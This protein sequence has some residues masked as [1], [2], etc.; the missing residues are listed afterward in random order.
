MLQPVQIT[1]GAPT[2]HLGLAA[3]LVAASFLDGT[4]KAVARIVCNRLMPS[5]SRLHCPQ[6]HIRHTLPFFF[7]TVEFWRIYGK[8]AKS[9]TFPSYASRALKPLCKVVS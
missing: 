9:C 2:V 1:D 7:C 6:K 4:F 5:P 3:D 8:M